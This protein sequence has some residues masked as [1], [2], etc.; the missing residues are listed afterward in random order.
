VAA[1]VFEDLS[2]LKVGAG[3]RAKWCSRVRGY[4]Y[5]RALVDTRRS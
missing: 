1:V 3:G 2:E 5:A 4:D